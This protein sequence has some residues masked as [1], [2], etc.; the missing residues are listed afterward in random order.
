MAG[1]SLPAGSFRA[2]IVPSSWRGTLAVAGAEAGMRA[3]AGLAP[4][5][6]ADGNG[7]RAPPDGT[8]FADPRAAPTI[9]MECFVFLATSLLPRPDP[10]LP[11]QPTASATRMK[12]RC[13]RR[14]APFLLDAAARI[15][16]SRAKNRD[17]S[18][19]SPGRGARHDHPGVVC[20]RRGAC[21]AAPDR[22]DRLDPERPGR[23]TAKLRAAAVR[24]RIG[25][26]PR[27]LRGT[28]T[29]RSFRSRMAVHSGAQA[30]SAENPRGVRRRPDRRRTHQER[31]DYR[32]NQ[33]R[34]AVPP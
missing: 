20:E 14:R 24:R 23:R 34:H 27:A 26:R 30:R 2:V 31:F 1:E 8:R 17:E 25:G 28:R 12:S 22:A 6:A 33:R 5:R 9:L 18:Y 19:V 21:G 3:G 4:A 15:G 29:G 16:E 10:V 32:D 7:R 11:P 13:A